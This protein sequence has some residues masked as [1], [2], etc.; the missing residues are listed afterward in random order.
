MTAFSKQLKGCETLFLF[1]VDRPPLKVKGQTEFRKV[2]FV[3]FNDL[4]SFIFLSNVIPCK[5]LNTVY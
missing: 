2:H 4:V 1:H 3:P 5:I